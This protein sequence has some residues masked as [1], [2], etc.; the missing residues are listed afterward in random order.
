MV[1]NTIPLYIA[2]TAYK[3]LTLLKDIL[4]SLINMV[5]G[6]LSFAFDIIRQWNPNAQI[7]QHRIYFALNTTEVLFLKTI[8]QKKNKFEL[9]NNMVRLKAC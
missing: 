6:K 8:I 1:V 2:S 5:N 7:L 4:L 9:S 3:Q